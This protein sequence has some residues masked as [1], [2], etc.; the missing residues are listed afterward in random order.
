MSNQVLTS[1][2]IIAN[3]FAIAIVYSVLKSLMSFIKNWDSYTTEQKV[4]SILLLI[5]HATA[6]FI[7]ISH[8]HRCRSGQGII[9]AIIITV[10]CVILIRNLLNVKASPR[11]TK[12]V[13]THYVDQ[14][15]QPRSE[16][17]GDRF[18]HF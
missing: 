6:A 5:V 7:L 13:M 9:K 2:Q 15:P 8:A 11:N 17:S 12:N 3:L 10:I 4:S 1:G 16:G 14:A 18:A